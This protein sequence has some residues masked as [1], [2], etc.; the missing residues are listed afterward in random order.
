MKK[1]VPF[2]F[3][4]LLFFAFLFAGCAS[5]NRTA[6]GT[7]NIKPSDDLSL[8]EDSSAAKSITGKIICYPAFDDGYKTCKNDE[9][10]FWFDLPLDWKVV[11]KSEDGSAY[12]IL[13]GNSNIELKVYGVLMGEE[14][15]SSFVKKLAGNTGEISDFDFRDGWTGKK[16]AVSENETYYVR[17]D[18]ESF[19]VFYVNTTEDP[20]WRAQNEEIVNNIAFSLRITRESF[21]KMEDEI[22]N[23]TPDDL[24]LGKIEV[25]MTYD[26]L[27]DVIGQEPSDAVDE[28]YDGMKTK[29]MCFSDNTQVYIVNNIVY[30]VN[31]VDPAYAT[32]RGLRPG[33]SEEK[34]LELYGEPNRKEDGIWG[35]NINGYE[36]LTIVT[37]DGVVTQIQIE[38]GVW[39]VEVY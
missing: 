32:P 11:D 23:I 6:S 18:G 37:E 3:A 29:M 21:G 25:G 22:S 17:V 36:L 28:D 13:T 20:E 8:A 4:N 10:D 14:T 5:D 1:L 16:I 26:A 31:V 39:D 9:F 27:L 15:E 35:Y 19:L 2:V 12:H 38:Q 34:I 30:T 7:V 24:K 33:D